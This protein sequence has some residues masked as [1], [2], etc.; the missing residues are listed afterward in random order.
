[1]KQI[2]VRNDRREEITGEQRQFRG[3]EG[4]PVDVLRAGK[5]EQDRVEEQ[6]ANHTQAVGKG[7]HRIAPS[8]DQG[9]ALTED[10]QDHG[11]RAH[12]RS[13]GKYLGGNEELQSTDQTKNHSS[14]RRPPLLA[15]QDLVKQ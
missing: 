14:R 4:W 10:E 13:A 1:M 9:V 11:D 8:L 12:H 7:C 2:V 15:H 6:Q 3:R 5:R